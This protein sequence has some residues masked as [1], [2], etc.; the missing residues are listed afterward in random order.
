MCVPLPGASGRPSIG[1][2]TQNSGKARPQAIASP[3]RMIRAMP[4][5]ARTAS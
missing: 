2:P 5:G 4:S 1:T 3:F